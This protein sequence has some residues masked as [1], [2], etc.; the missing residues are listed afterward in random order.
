MTGILRL[1]EQVMAAPLMQSGTADLALTISVNNAT[2]GPGK[3]DNVTFT[4]TI[5]NTSTTDDATGV[6]VQDI[7]PAG[8]TY[9]SDTSGGVYDSGSGTW[10][11]GN[12]AA[13]GIIS[14]DLT[15]T[16]V[17]GAPK[18]NTAQITAS[19]PIDPN[20]ANNSASVTVTPMG[21]DLS[22][23][24]TVSNTAPN[25]TD[26]IIFTI[27]VTNNSATTT[28]TGVTVKDLL[29]AGLTYASDSG[30]GTYNRT[31]GIWVV[32]AVPASSAVTLNIIANATTTGN[33]T[34]SAEIWTS[35]Q[36]DPNSVPGNNSTTEDDDDSRIVDSQFRRCKPDYDHSLRQCHTEYR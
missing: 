17:T 2:P 10:T 14:L 29:P 23:A 13:N 9:V 30:A 32:G 4:I 19:M 15:A 31:T 21:V 11:I 12:L 27:T 33:K 16:V 3:T 26:N 22:L 18:T 24:M 20:A 34:N 35:D 25:R 1:P 5:T 8:L 36:L 28:A 7:L 6:T